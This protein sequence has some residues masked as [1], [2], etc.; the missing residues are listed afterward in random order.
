[1]IMPMPAA[2]TRTRRMVLPTMLDSSGVDHP[3]NNAQVGAE[4]WLVLKADTPTDP[5]EHAVPGAAAAPEAD[6]AKT[7]AEKITDLEKQIEDLTAELE[8]EQEAR[9]EA[10]AKAK[11]AAD[12]AAADKAA[13]AAPDAPTD[14]IEK[15]LADGNL[16][17]VLKAALRAQADQAKADRAL[18]AKMADAEADREF[19]AKAADY[20]TLVTPATFGPVLKAAAAG[21]TP[22]AYTELDRVLKSAA[23]TVAEADRVLTATVGSAQ[24]PDATSAAGEIAKLAVAKRAADPSLTPEQ[25]EAAAWDERPDLV[26]KYRTEGA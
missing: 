6:K 23:E 7:D 19:I 17:P 26:V 5:K 4:G 20:G 24:H 13:A 8:K 1:M 22:E 3:A 10:E 25:A 18:V 9:K 2:G 14:P 21:M 15:A 11:E 16:D 12:K